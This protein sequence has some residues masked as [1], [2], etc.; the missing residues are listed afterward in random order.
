MYKLGNKSRDKLVG[1][2][3][4]LVRVVELAIT[5]TT[6]DFAVHDGLRS[7]QEQIALVAKGASKT[8]NSKH[9]KQPDGWGH[10]VDLVPYINGQLRWEWKPIF[11]IS[12]AVDQAAAKLGVRIRWGGVWDRTMDMYGGSP[13]AVKK[14]VYDYCARHTG[15]DFIDGPHFELV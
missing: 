4:D 3:P 2:H 12:S 7:D 9:K 11:H 6:Q 13:D 14:A 1:V 10:A 5:L 15:P 8:L